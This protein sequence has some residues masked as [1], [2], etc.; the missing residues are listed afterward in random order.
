MLQ[1][2][3]SSGPADL[4]GTIFSSSPTV[5]FETKT[6]SH[7]SY[8]ARVAEYLPQSGSEN[9]ASSVPMKLKMTL[10]R[11]ALTLISARKLKSARILSVR[12][13]RQE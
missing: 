8:T 2:I 11:I 3:F 7:A 5:S 4:T 10:G 6:L 9:L 13:W 12:V 1:K